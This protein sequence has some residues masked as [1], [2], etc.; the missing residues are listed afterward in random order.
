MEYVREVGELRG[1]QGIEEGEC[2]MSVEPIAMIVPLELQDLPE[3]LTPESSASSSALEGGDHHTSPSSNSPSEETP[4]REE[5]TGN[6][7]G[8]EPNLPV[9]E[10]W[11]NRVIRSR[12]S[13]LR[14]APKDLPAGFR[15]RA[16]LHHEVANRAPSISGYK[17]LEEMVRSYQIPR[18]ILLRAGT[19]NERACTVFDAADAQQHKVHHRLYTVV[20]EV[21]GIG[22]GD[23][24]QV[25]VPVSAV[26]KLQKCEVVLP[27]WEGEEPAL[28]KSYLR[29]S[30]NEH[31]AQGIVE[32]GLIPNFKLI[33]TSGHLL[34]QGAVH[35]T[36]VRA[37]HQDHIPSRELKLCPPVQ[38]GARGK[39]LTPRM[40]F[41]LSCEGRARDLSPLQ[42]PQHDLPTVCGVSCLLQIG[43]VLRGTSSSMEG[44][45]VQNRELQQNCKQLASEKASLAD[46]AEKESG[47]QAAREEAGHAEDQAKKAEA[48]REKTLHEL[49]ALKERVV[50][51]DL[52]VAWAEAS[53]EKTKRVH[54]R[55]I[56]FAHAQGAEW[57]V[58]ADM[59]QDAVA[60]ATANT[61]TNIF[62]E[63]R[64]KVLRHRPDFPIGE[65]AFFE[66]EDI[67]DEGKSLAPPADTWVRLKWELDEEELPVWPPFIIEEGEVEGLPSF[68][69]WVAEP[70]E[71]A[72][73]PCGTPPSSLPQP[74]PIAA[75]ALS[76][77]DRSS[78]AR[79][80][81]ARMDVSVPVDLTDD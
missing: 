24:V 68:D 25:A 78:P 16:A 23:S 51:A 64:G 2:V 70:Q 3:T 34:H 63:V 56:C 46:E 54:Q 1:N 6:V 27:L 22:Q 40:I 79:S 74:A 72:A 48:D 7:V 33:L 66:G 42:P 61:T 9:V 65:L 43:N 52:Y 44:A 55:N 37:R 28:K 13:N 17:K 31:K 45:R 39:T 58:G 18:T 20:C 10:E 30:A 15:F 11:E 14:K 8:N 19:K 73:E 21:G 59:F 69:A 81:A 77:L 32:L 26:P 36:E 75:P 4:S 62:N 76:P 49:N 38:E 50:N 71:V 60:V 5:E 29:G 67:D 35:P 53:L 47:I 12:L 80:D 41:P 57:L